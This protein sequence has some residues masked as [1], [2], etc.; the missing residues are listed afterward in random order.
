MN[1]QI[2]KPAFEDVVDSILVLHSD[3]IHEQETVD[4][5]LKWWGDG[6]YHEH[7][8]AFQSERTQKR[9]PTLVKLVEEICTLFQQ[10][11]LE[12]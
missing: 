7:W 4:L 11:T 3:E 12:V 8:L 9:I 10:V 1:E 2:G 6:F 5:Q